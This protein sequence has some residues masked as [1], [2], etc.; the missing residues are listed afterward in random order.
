VFLDVPGTPSLL[1]ADD[2]G[3]N[4]RVQLMCTGSNTQ[5]KP[6]ELAPVL[7]YMW[8]V[9]GQPMN[10]TGVND[11]SVVVARNSG[12]SYRCMTHEAGSR[13]QSLPSNELLML[14]DSQRSICNVCE[15][16]QIRIL[17]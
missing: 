8:M 11:T 1:R 17:T 7:Q 4:D 14:P 2:A 16:S 3:D 6:S 5:S 9:D 12:L 10:T 15:S 13:L